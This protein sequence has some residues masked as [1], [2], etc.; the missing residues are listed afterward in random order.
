MTWHLV[1]DKE[2]FVTAACLRGAN[3]PVVGPYVRVLVLH[4]HKLLEVGAL[5]QVLF[6]EDHGVV[7]GLPLARIEYSV[8]CLFRSLD[9]WRGVLKGVL[10]S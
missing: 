8:F 9:L 10:G 4:F 5:D 6:F 1:H 2:A 3:I 7:W